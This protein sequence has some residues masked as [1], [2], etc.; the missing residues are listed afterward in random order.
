[1]VITLTQE[2]EAALKEVASRC[3]VAPEVLAVDALRDRFLGTA[4]PVQPQDEWERRRTGRSID[5]SA[6]YFSSLFCFFS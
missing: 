1:M 6:Q 2:L 5:G 4:A 3:G